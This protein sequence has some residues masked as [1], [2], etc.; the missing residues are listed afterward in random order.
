MKKLQL[1][2]L[3]CLIAFSCETKKNEPAKT[4]PITIGDISRSE[5]CR[6]SLEGLSKGD[7]DSFVEAMATNAVY[8]FNNGDSLVGKESITNYWRDRRE[9]VIDKITFSS[10]VWLVVNVNESPSSRVLTGPWVMGWFLAKA[11]YKTGKSMEQWIHTDYHLNE[12]GK[13]DRVIQY[14]DRQAINQALEAE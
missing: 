3:S 6:K 2:L 12:E 13:I 5:I 11:T 7:I 8:V 4:E 9:N 14:L 1:L 10:D